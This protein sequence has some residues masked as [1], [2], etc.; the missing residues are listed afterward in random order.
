MGGI[1]QGAAERKMINMLHRA[2]E[3]GS[4]RGGRGGDRTERSGIS[5][6][7][8]EKCKATGADEVR[9]EM[10]EMA[11]DRSQVYRKAMCMKE[12]R[13]PKVWTM[14]LVVPIW[15]RKGDVHDPGK[16]KSRR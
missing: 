4:E 6:G 7:Q 14:G 16:W 11:G 3:L 9:L 10:V 2:P 5:N 12:G 8:A 15:K 13:I 1:L